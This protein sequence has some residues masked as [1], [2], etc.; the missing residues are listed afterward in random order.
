MDSSFQRSLD[1]PPVF[2]LTCVFPVSIHFCV[3]LELLSCLAKSYTTKKKFHWDDVNV[4]D[5]F[6]C[7]S[8]LQRIE[9]S[10]T[11]FH[12][13]GKLGKPDLIALRFVGFLSFGGGFK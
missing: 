5:P 13:L 4:V 8:S 3:C 7:L 10:S 9:S 11:A 6:C 2:P 12:E 1:A